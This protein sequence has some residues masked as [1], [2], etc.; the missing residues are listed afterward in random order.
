[1]K[2]KIK[3][4]FTLLLLILMPV[5]TFAQCPQTNKAFKAGEHLEYN[6]YFNWKFVWIKCGTATYDMRRSTYRGN[7]SLYNYLLFKTNPKF[8]RFF[9]LRDTLKCHMTDELIPE[10]FFKA[11]LEGSRHRI[12]EVWYSYPDGKSHVKIRYVDPDGKQKITYDTRSNGCTYDMMSMMAVARSWSSAS[13]KV[14]QKMHFPMTASD[15]VQNVVVVY[16]GRKKEKM[17][18]GHTYNC[19]VFSVLDWDDK[20]SDKEILRFFFTDDDNHVPLRIDFYLKFGTAKAFITKST[21][22]RNPQKSIVK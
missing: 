1:M 11:S 8:D 5:Y 9:C 2:S 20:K 7:S 21:G 4:S 10:Y 12:E 22:L 18:D 13:I 14:G 3:A 6:L 16:N 15:R 17:D 19:L